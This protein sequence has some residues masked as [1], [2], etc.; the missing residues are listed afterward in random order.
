MSAEDKFEPAALLKECSKISK[1]E[2]IGWKIED[3]L[4]TINKQLYDY[5][6]MNK[7]YETVLEHIYECYL[8]GLL[9]LPS[10][11]GDTSYDKQKVLNMLLI[12]DIDECHSG[13]YPPFYDKIEEVKEEEAIFNKGLFIKGVHNNIADLTE[14][15]ELWQSWENDFADDINIKIAYEID[16]IQMIYKML[17]L[18]KDTDIKLSGERIQRFLM[19]KRKIKT[20]EGKKI[21]EIIITKNADFKD[22]FDSLHNCGSDTYYGSGH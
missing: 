21:Y 10:R 6:K 8:I 9:Y 2:K 1:T 22:L 11:S 15:L 16:K 4:T 20:E 13:D 3:D 12:H 7:S 17:R 18:L 19:D 14:Y 5:Y